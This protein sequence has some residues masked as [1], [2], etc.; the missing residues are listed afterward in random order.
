MS[1]CKDKENSNKNS[2][3]RS[4]IRCFVTITIPSLGKNFHDLVLIVGLK[5]NSLAFQIMRCISSPQLIMSLSFRMV[6]SFE[7]DFL[8][9]VTVILRARSL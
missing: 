8:L 3:Y 6:F 2:S 1:V 7:P 4:I 5:I 9:P